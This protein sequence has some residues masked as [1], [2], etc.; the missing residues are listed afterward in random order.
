MEPRAPKHRLEAQPSRIAHEYGRDVM[1]IPPAEEGSRGWRRPFHAG[2]H[3]VVHDVPPRHPPD[4]AHRQTERVPGRE[5]PEKLSFVGVTQR[6]HDLVRP[7][8]GSVRA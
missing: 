3:L 8:D 5:L 1:V 4:V 7:E 6:V 2:P